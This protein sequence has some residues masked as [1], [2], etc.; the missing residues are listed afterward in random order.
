M[1]LLLRAAEALSNSK[2]RCWRSKSRRCERLACYFDLLRQQKRWFCFRIKDSQSQHWRCLVKSYREWYGFSSA[3]IAYID[4][5]SFIACNMLYESSRRKPGWRFTAGVKLEALWI[6]KNIKISKIFIEKSP[7]CWRH[8]E[9]RLSLAKK[10]TLR[11]RALRFN[12]HNLTKRLRPS[13]AVWSKVPRQNR[14]I[15][16]L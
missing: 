8:I 7:I 2:F 13:D 6:V 5:K 10:I 16:F 9:R 4:S 3:P 15:E 1:K 14:Q 12:I 11:D